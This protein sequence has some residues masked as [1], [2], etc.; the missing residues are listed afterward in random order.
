MLK[1]KIIWRK[2]DYKNEYGKVLDKEINEMCEDNFQAKTQTGDIIIEKS[3]Y[4]RKIKF[5]VFRVEKVGEMVDGIETLSRQRLIEEL[6]E[7]T[8]RREN[9]NDKTKNK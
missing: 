3:Q 8:K 2:P 4:G 9:K 5:I 6:K 7:I 1:N